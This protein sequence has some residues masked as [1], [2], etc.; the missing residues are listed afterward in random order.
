MTARQLVEGRIT[1]VL[2]APFLFPGVDA[3]AF[4]FDK[5]AL[6]DSDGRLIV[7]MDQVRGLLRHGLVDLGRSD[8]LDDLFGKGSDDS[9]RTASGS[10]E[11]DRSAL[12]LSDLV[13]EPVSERDRAIAPMHRVKI[14]PETGAAAEGH[15]L[16]LEQLAAPGAEV[17]FSGAFH[18]L[19][20]ID[21][22]ALSN[23][24]SAALR[25]HGAIGSLKSVGFGEVVGWTV[26]AAVASAP[27]PLA[28]PGGDRLTLRF[29]LDRPYL[30][31][32]DRIADNAYLGR[33]DIPGGAIKGLLAQNLMLGGQPADPA[34][35][36]ALRIGHARPFGGG[37]LRMEERV[38]TRINADT[39]AAFDEQLYS[40][41][42]VVHDPKGFACTLDLTD[43]PQDQRAALVPALGRPLFGLGMTG[44]TLQPTAIIGLGSAD[45]AKPGPFAIVVRTPALLADP[46]DDPGDGAFASFQAFW[47]KHLPNSVLTACKARQRLVGGY[48]ALRFRIMPGQ[49]RPWVL[50]EPG[51]VFEFDLAAQDVAE[52]NRL[53]RRGLNR[54][55]LGG[56]VL[57]WQNCP[58]VAENGYG[59][60]ASHQ[61]SASNSGDAQ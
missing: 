53:L 54:T 9:T 41:I 17:V 33:R 40:T 5:V 51:S 48:H 23:A 39:G 26:S 61:P 18:A 8:V 57:N 13:A 1:V 29:T 2:R 42:A 21:P 55:S 30:V 15:L 22:V 37:V 12:F 38:H 59:E 24:L 27:A 47:K 28:D 44:A 46:V 19:T 45:S 36:A 43:V 50:T 35:L 16:T 4:G 49:Y 6:R 56:T 58:F 25:V 32:A 20:T 31:D 7:P 3:G 10:Y 60:L 52:M 11:P 14:D 34:A